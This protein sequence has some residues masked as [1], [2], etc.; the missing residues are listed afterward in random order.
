MFFSIYTDTREISA[1]A[2]NAASAFQG[3]VDAIE[4]ANNASSVALDAANEALG[5]VSVLIIATDKNTWKLSGKGWFALL[6]T[7]LF[8][9][10]Q[11]NGVGESSDNSK[12]NSTSL[13][14]AAKARLDTTEVGQ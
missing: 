2:L 14:Q 1:N 5:K 9:F 7:V 10:L 8:V 11:S 13:L 12:K 3:I 4:D 6:C